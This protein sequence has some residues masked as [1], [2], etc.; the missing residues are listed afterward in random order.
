MNRTYYF[1]LTGNQQKQFDSEYVSMCFDAAKEIQDYRTF[2]RLTI[3]C[4][5]IY[6]EHDTEVF[7]YRSDKKVDM[8]E[9]FW[10]KLQSKRIV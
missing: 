7:Y 1:K 9:F 8:K 3:V 5:T 2:S 6:V 10:V 4:S